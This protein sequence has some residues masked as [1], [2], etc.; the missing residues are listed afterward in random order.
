MLDEILALQ[1]IVVKLAGSIVSLKIE[2]TSSVRRT[3]FIKGYFPFP[4]V[5]YFT[6]LGIDP[7]YK[8]PTAFSVSSEIH[9][10][11]GV[12]EIAQVSIWQQVIFEP[13]PNK[14]GCM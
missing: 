8:G 14:N 6:S 3:E 7:R 11:S 5:G 4:C 9:W 10:Q 2:I 12:N 13:N 1:L